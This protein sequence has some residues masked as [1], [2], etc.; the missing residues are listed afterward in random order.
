VGDV[1]GL[2]EASARKIEP[3]FAQHPALTERACA[4]ITATDQGRIV[5]WE[6][7]HAP[8]ELNGSRGIFRAPQ[9]TC[10]LSAESDYAAI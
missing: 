3:F 7:L 8:D 5:P 1:P 9:Q 4:L 10:T 6:R 2:G